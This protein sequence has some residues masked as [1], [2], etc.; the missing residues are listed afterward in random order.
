MDLKMTPPLRT[1]LSLHTPPGRLYVFAVVACNIIRASASNAWRRPNACRR[2]KIWGDAR[3]LFDF[4][5][6]RHMVFATRAVRHGVARTVVM[7]MPWGC[8]GVPMASPWRVPSCLQHNTGQ[9]RSMLGEGRTLAVGGKY[10]GGVPCLAFSC[11]V[12]WY[13]PHG[14]SWR[15]TNCHHG[16]AMEMSWHHH[17]V[18]SWFF[19]ARFFVACHE[20]HHGICMVLPHGICHGI[21]SWRF[22]CDTEWSMA[23]PRK[24]S[25]PLC[26]MRMALSRQFVAMS[27]VAM[28]LLP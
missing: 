19:T 18:P 28:E 24:L 13:S 6:A 8:H 9:A 10:G 22:Q 25:W 20:I 11:R 1:S 3:T 21:G 17:G 23:T 15:R 7:V 26:D 16:D 4:F 5:M 14:A 12:I 2:W 27:W